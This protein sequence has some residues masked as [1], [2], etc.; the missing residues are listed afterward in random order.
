VVPKEAFDA[1]QTAVAADNRKRLVN[2]QYWPEI[3]GNFI[4]AFEEEGRPKS[5]VCDRF[6]L[7]ACEDPSGDEGCR[8]V[9]RSIRNAEPAEVLKALDL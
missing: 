1:I 4:V 7:V 5:I 3:F 9:L 8:T 6:E 2:A